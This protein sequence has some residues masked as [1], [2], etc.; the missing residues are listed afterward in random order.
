M[1]NRVFLTL[2]TSPALDTNKKSKHY[3]IKCDSKEECEKGATKLHYID[4]YTTLLTF[5]IVVLLMNTL[6]ITEV[7]EF[8]CLKEGYKEPYYKESRKRDRGKS[9][10][11]LREEHSAGTYNYLLLV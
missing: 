10:A 8:Q 3:T 2:T 7:Y 9:T 11:I 4:I 6:N 5:F 1:S